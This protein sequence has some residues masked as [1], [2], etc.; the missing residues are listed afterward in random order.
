M[1]DCLRKRWESKTPALSYS[2]F[3]EHVT[4]AIVP[5]SGDTCCCELFNRERLVTTPLVDQNATVSD[6][7]LDRGVTHRYDR[8][9]TCHRL[10]RRHT[11]ALV[12]RREYQGPRGP[13]QAREIR[14]AQTPHR[15]QVAASTKQPLA[16]WT[17]HHQLY[18]CSSQGLPNRRQPVESLARVVNPPIGHAHDEW[19]TDPEPREQSAMILSRAGTEG[20]R[21]RQRGNDQPISRYVQDGR[22]SICGE[23]RKR[24]YALGTRHELLQEKPRVEAGLLVV[25]QLERNEIQHGDDVATPRVSRARIWVGRV[26]NVV[27]VGQEVALPVHEI[28][29]ILRT[30]AAHSQGARPYTKMLVFRRC[31]NGSGVASEA[32]I[33][34]RST[35][36]RRLDYHAEGLT[37][38]LI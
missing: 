17:S 13:K 16:F 33:S 26:E 8:R 27:V 36:R 2:A 14:V 1:R 38:R 28:T 25:G 21:G 29:D 9:P 31:E 37:T 19:I 23:L 12:G 10:E 6:N 5:A 22:D 20:V 18:T 24:K 32:A 11:L 7:L 4:L 3:T 15:E 30:T 35:Q 34:S